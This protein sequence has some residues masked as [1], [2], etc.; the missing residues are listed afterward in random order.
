VQSNEL[1]TQK[2][3]AILDTRRDSDGL[4]TTG[5]DQSID[6]PLRR[7]D[8]AGLSNLEPAVTRTGRRVLGSVVDLLHVSHDGALVGGVDDFVIG[9]AVG[10]GGRQGVEP[11]TSDGVTSLDGNYF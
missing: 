7:R 9:A 2:V 10:A 5:L 6:G 3:V 11:V 4:D 1:E 8:E